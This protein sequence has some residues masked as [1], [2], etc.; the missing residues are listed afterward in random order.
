MI[1]N[2]LFCPPVLPAV[3]HIDSLREST[4]LISRIIIH[5]FLDFTELGVAMLSSVLR[6]SVAIEI[7]IEIMRAFVEIRKMISGYEELSQKIQQLE[8]ETNMQFNEIY[9]ALTELAS[10]NNQKQNRPNPVGYLSYQLKK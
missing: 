3:I 1:N 6:S 8:S 4:N 7:N 2:L 9:Q 10:V 5:K